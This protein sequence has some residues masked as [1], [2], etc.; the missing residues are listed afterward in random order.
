MGDFNEILRVE[1]KQGWLGRPKRQMQ[2]FQNALDYCG[3]KDLGYPLLGVTDDLVIIMFRLGWIKKW[4]QWIGCSNFLLPLYTIWRL[5]ILIIDQSSC[6]QTQS[7]R[8]SI[9]RVI[10]FGLKLCG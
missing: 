5:L 8:D 4:L 7:K 6:F 10:L 3:L 1:E 2:G 9:R